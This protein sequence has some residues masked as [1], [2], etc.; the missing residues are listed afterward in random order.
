MMNIINGGAHADNPIDIQEF[1]IM[2]GRPSNCGRGDPHGLRN[3]P[4]RCK[5]KLKDAGH[6]TNV[7][8]EGGFAPNLASADDALGFVM[9]AIEAAGYRPGEDIMLALDAASTEFFKDGKYNLA[10]EGKVLDAAE[11]WSTTG[12]IWSAATR[13]SR[14]RTAWPRTTGKAGRCSPPQSARR[15]SWSATTCS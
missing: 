7:G 8:D 12:P 6:N 15:S 9:Q 4:R 5:K 13:S 11:P 1:M 10:G 14:S 3:V 2:P